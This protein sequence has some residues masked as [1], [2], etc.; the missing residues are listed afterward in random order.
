[1]HGPGASLWAAGGADQQPLRG[2]SLGWGSH[3]VSTYGVD[4][5]MGRM[6]PER[7]TQE[8]SLSLPCR[9]HSNSR[10]LFSVRCSAV[11]TQQ[12]AEIGLPGF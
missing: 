6:A 11:D 8:C 12:S 5:Q 7:A 3:G 10:A 9:I 2:Q 1:M 4:G